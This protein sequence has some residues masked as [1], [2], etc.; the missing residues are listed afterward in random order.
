M[1]TFALLATNVKKKKQTQKWNKNKLENMR[2]FLTLLYKQ[3]KIILL[4]PLTAERI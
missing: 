1:G 4:L 2:I 3:N